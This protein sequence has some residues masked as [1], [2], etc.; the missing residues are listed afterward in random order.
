MNTRDQAIETAG[1]DFA[2]LLRTRASM[3]PRE[4]AEASWTPTSPR[5]VDELEDLIRVERGLE[6]RARSA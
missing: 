5:T 6:P 2:T 3:T 4:L 1:R